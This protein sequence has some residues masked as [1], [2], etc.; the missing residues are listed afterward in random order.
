MIKWIVLVILATPVCFGQ[1]FAGSF[2]SNTAQSICPADNFGGQTYPFFTD[3]HYLFDAWSSAWTDTKRNRLVP[4]G[5]GH[6]DYYGNQILSLSITGTPTWSLLTNPSPITSVGTC[7]EA[8]SDGKP[9]GRH[10]YNQLTYIEHAD[11]YYSF[12]GSVSCGNGYNLGDTWTFAPATSTWTQKDP[13]TNG[14]GQLPYHQAIINT[15]SQSAGQA[16]GVA[17]YDRE[18]RLVYLQWT[19]QLWSYNYD[20]NTY[21]R[22]AAFADAHVPYAATGVIDPVRRTMLYMGHEFGVTNP[23]IYEINMKSGTTWASADVTS[24]YVGCNALA[25]A[26][27]PGLV[28]DASI[29]KVVGY[30]GTGNSVYI[31][32]TIAKTCTLL[33]FT[34][35]PTQATGH[36]GIFGRFAYFPNIG[37]YVIANNMAVA[38]YSFTLHLNAKH[39]MGSSTTTCVDKDGDGYGVG[40]S[41]TGADADDHD[42]SVHTGA[43]AITKYGTLTAFLATRGYNPT[44]IWYI[45]TT[46]NDGTCKSGSAPVGIGSPCASWTP[47]HTAQ[48]AGD[49]IIVRGGTYSSLLMNIANGTSGAP[50]IVMAYPG[51][52]PLLTSPIAGV[53]IV[54]RSFHI[55]DGLKFLTSSCMSGGTNDGAGSSL[56]HNNQY[57]HIEASDCLWGFS[58]FNGLVDIALRDSSYHDMDGSSEEHGIYVGSRDIPSTTVHV[59]RN[60]LYSNNRN[61]IHM[62]GRMANGR[63]EQN[64]AYLNGISGYD[65]QMGVN[66]S[67]LL[68]NISFDNA[69][70]DLVIYNYYGDCAAVGSG[71]GNICPYDQTNNLIEGNTFYGTAVDPDGIAVITQSN[72]SVTNAAVG[73]TGNLGSNTFRNNIMVTQGNGT[74]YP[75]IIYYN[76]TADPGGGCVPGTQVANATTAAYLSSSTFTNNKFWHVDGN[77]SFIGHGPFTSS[78]GWQPYTC[79]TAAAITTLSGCTN[80]DPLFTAASTSLHGLPASFDFRLQSTSTAISAGSPLRISRFDVSGT[81]MPIATAPSLGALQ[82]IGSAPAT[83]LSGI[84]GN[85]KITGAGTIR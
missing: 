48:L 76:C 36:A 41:C 10:S 47:I 18:T 65:W 22:L 82:S 20:T 32:D 58:A 68:Q 78:F 57:L 79:A 38:S 74:H 45:A 66:H 8:L 6:N 29:D 2:S 30:I 40:A 56:F 17:L 44:R 55:I 34:G 63:V 12:G 21:T 61:G 28:Y 1:G 37:K 46:G 26:D 62:N 73:N 64:V 85:G 60:L 25:A 15:G 9:N 43:Q 24:S 39:G 27:Y 33:P 77:N 14:G 7:A 51:E 19:D 16:W 67:Y 84:S 75:S 81:E 3:C 69:A 72:I 53:S 59:K 5:G 4:W 13:A 50:I 31:V 80:D 35:G 23:L 11:I 42:A 70:N 54:E 83:P 49:M 71:T 52:L